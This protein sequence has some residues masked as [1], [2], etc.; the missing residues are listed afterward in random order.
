MI[1]KYHCC[2]KELESTQSTCKKWVESC[3][4]YEMLLEKQIKSNVK[5]GVGFRLNM[6]MTKPPQTK[7]T[8]TLKWLK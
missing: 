2:K 3:T 6:I 8:L 4:I 1:E 7:I 5:F